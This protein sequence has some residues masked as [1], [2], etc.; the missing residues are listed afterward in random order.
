M[1]IQ[2]NHLLASLGLFVFVGCGPAMSTITG[3][4][5]VDGKP[6]AKGTITFAAL[7]G[8]APPA[9]AT[10]AD[11]RYELTTV[12]GNKRVLVSA[13]VFVRKQ[14]EYDGPDAPMIDIT[15]ESL[16]DR[17]HANSELTFDAKAG[18]NVKDWNLEGKKR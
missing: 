9:S 12:A 16:P 18:A 10:I 6:V 14:K 11:G 15:A 5:K 8:P 2:F 4:V 13:P 3:E 1:S 7:D 17:Y